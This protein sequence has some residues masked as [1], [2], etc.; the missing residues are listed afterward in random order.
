MKN[1]TRRNTQLI[2]TTYQLKVQF[3]IFFATLWLASFSTKSIQKEDFETKKLWALFLKPKINYISEMAG[4]LWTIFWMNFSVLF[5]QIIIPVS[6]ESKSHTKSFNSNT[7]C[8]T[9]V[10]PR[11]FSVFHEQKYWIVAL[12]LTQ[13]KIK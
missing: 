1:G 2:T 7:N 4:L 9:S 5:F 10:G 13:S 12:L 11:N 3:V 8:E 6:Y